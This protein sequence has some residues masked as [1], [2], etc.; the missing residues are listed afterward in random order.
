MTSISIMNQCACGSGPAAPNYDCERCRLV[1]FVRLV[2]TM[3][4]AQRA[5]FRTRKPEAM[6]YACELEAKVDD[7]TKRFLAQPE[8]TLFP[9]DGS[10]TYYELGG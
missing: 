1:Y 5:Y 3:R 2:E 4:T 8:E 9:E 6:K 7:L 10:G